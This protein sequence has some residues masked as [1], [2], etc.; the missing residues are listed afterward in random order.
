MDRLTYNK[1]IIPLS[2]S[3]FRMAKS[4]LQDEDEAKDTVQ[5]LLLKF[6]EMRDQLSKLD[7]PKAFAFKSLRNRCLDIIR[8]RKEEG[9]LDDTNCDESPNPYEQI[10]I[11]DAVKQVYELIERLPELQRSIL[12]MRDVE[13][14]EIAEI[15][16]IMD[17]KENAVSVNLSRARK[18]IREEMIKNH[19]R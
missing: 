4:I 19:N 15:A 8:L 5:D 9:D 13:G 7:N 6:W 12:R 2:D 10:E 16:E 18:K 1:T 11:Q 17:M 3:L 14:M